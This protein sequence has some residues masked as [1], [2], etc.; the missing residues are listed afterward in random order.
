[1]STSGGPYIVSGSTNGFKIVDGKLQAVPFPASDAVMEFDQ[2]GRPVVT[3]LEALRAGGY[4]ADI[5]V[6]VEIWK[7]RD[8]T[9][10]CGGLS[11]KTVPGALGV[12][13]LLAEMSELNVLGHDVTAQVTARLMRL[14]PVGAL[15]ENAMQGPRRALE[16]FGDRMPADMRQSLEQDANLP[17]RDTVKPGPKPLLSD[18][19]LRTV[20]VPAYLAGGRAP[21]RAVQEALAAAGFNNGHVSIDQAR[22]AVSRARHADPPLLGPARGRKRT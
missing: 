2:D 4:Y 3:D 17:S 22:K 20:V 11:V 21:V 6:D 5:Q 13:D 16:R 1:M 10:F 19:L 8:G 15:V 9:L 18:E 7:D 12:T 14:L